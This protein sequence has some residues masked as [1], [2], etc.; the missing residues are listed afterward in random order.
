MQSGGF[1]KEEIDGNK[2]VGNDYLNKNLKFSF[3]SKERP[4]SINFAA[5]EKQ[6]Y[7]AKIFLPV[8]EKSKLCL[9]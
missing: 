1:E 7:K 6:A 5:L 3:I 4:L 8:A 9:Q 2:S